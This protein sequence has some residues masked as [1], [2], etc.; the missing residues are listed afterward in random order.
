MQFPQSLNRTQLPLFEAFMAQAMAPIQLEP[1]E[2]PWS[3]DSGP[4]SEMTLSGSLNH[5]RHLLGP[6]LR[7]MSQNQDARW[8]T[9]VAPPASVTTAWLRS[10]GLNL[11]RLMLLSPSADKDA[12]ELACE[13]LR[14]G[15]SHTVI[16]WVM[17]VD[18]QV[19]Q[20]LG[21]AARQGGAQSLNIRLA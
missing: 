12:L 11:D 8:L 18:Q 5:C 17:P 16:S 21:N 7:E 4:F 2:Q 10:L 13:A 3:E 14:L 6:I 20:R 19:R 1:I 15:R 9:L